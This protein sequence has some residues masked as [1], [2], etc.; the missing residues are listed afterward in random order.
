[1]FFG[2]FLL[3]CGAKFWLIDRFGNATP[4][5]DEWETEAKIIKSCVE[6]TL[7]PGQFF[8]SHNEHRIAYSQLFTVLL[9]LANGIW[10][11]ILQMVAQ[12]PL[13]AMGVVAFVSLA[14]RCM[15]NIGRVAL[16]G[17]AGLVSVLP[18]GWENTLWGDQSCFY[19]SM[20]FAIVVIWMA[21]RYEPLTPGWWVGA[22][23][24][25]ASLF[26]LASGTL[27]I[28]AVTLF[29]AVRLII[30]RGKGWRKE[31]AGVVVFAGIAICGVLITPHLNVTNETVARNFT[32]FLWALTGV[33]S[34]PCRPHWACAIIQ[35]PLILLLLRSLLGRISFRD[36]RWFV[37]TL[38]ISF[39]IQALATA[40]RRCKAWD[41]VRY[42]DPWAMLLIVIFSCLY[43]LRGSLP[44]RWQFLIYP[45]AGV[46]LAVCLYG[47]IDRTVNSLP[48]QIMDKYTTMM[49]L[50]NNVREYLGTGNASWLQGKIP[51]RQEDLLQ[52]KLDDKTIRGALPSNLISRNP[53]LSP[54]QE[55]SGGGGFLK[56]GFPDRLPPLDK[57]AVGSF[58]KKDAQSRSGVTFYFKAPRGA[59][60]VNIQVAGYPNARGI[61]LTIEEQ[62]RAPYNIAPPID[63]GENWQTVF[64]RLHQ[65]STVFKIS[66]K[67]ES[68]GSWI[69]FSM[70]VV[71]TGGLPGRWARSLASESFLII[72]LGLVLLLIGALGEIA[73]KG[74][75]ENIF[76]A[77]RGT[78]KM[79]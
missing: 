4:Y 9:F 32:D 20:L 43:F 28:L 66:A 59:R 38:G 73:T 7:S 24:G 74:T 22:F 37:I 17:F 69:A 36:G 45:I 1:M 54:V 70:P 15:S 65:K 31:A 12:A 52:Q 78:A 44:K 79:G 2:L 35:A 55:K 27:S 30:E 62:H 16:A 61:A 50:E 77:D 71:A 57:P 19:F 72:D 75:E 13:L 6:G 25:F 10:D 34:W 76:N 5:W 11:P 68:D 18:F 33:L 56:S 26:A 42:Y 8:E 46:W 29:L 14:G 41:S 53:P 58:G 60:E 64:I 40:Y 67:D 63:P 3:I 39:W 47:V 51:F 49:E 48:S 21:W 23:L